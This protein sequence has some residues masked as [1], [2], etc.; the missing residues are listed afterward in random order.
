MGL[1]GI[2]VGMA[3]G[4]ILGGGIAIAFIGI[5]RRPVI[6]YEDFSEIR[7]NA[8]NEALETAA[9]TLEGFVKTGLEKEDLLRQVD[10]IRKLKRPLPPEAT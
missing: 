5:V 7:W 10:L 1:Q 6:S 8:Y 2:L 9:G 4:F 3:I